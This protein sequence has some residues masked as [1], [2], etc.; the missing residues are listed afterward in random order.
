[1]IKLLFTEKKMN[2]LIH[3][4]GNDTALIEGFRKMFENRFQDRLTITDY[5]NTS[6][7]GLNTSSHELAKG[8]RGF[9]E[10]E[11]Y[12]VM[13]TTNLYIS[14]EL[15]DNIDENQL[16][17]DIKSYLMND[18][19]LDSEREFQIDNNSEHL[20]PSPLLT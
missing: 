16:I 4:K 12:F 10:T 19:K 9:I 7:A 2:I 20:T 13:A 6:Q 1:M 18:F 3:K 17:E 8:R 15:F 5:K 11:R 14:C